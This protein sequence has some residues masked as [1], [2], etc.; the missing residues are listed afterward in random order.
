MIVTAS[1]SNER[2]FEQ[3]LVMLASL[4]KNSVMDDVTVHLIDCTDEHKNRVLKVLPV[5]LI[6]R[7]SC[8]AGVDKKGFMV[9]YRA[10]AVLEAMREW[11]GA[12]AWFDTDVIV[13]K[14][15]HHFWDDVRPTCLKV[16]YR[17]GAP[18]RSLF[19]AGIFAVGV[20]AATEKMVEWWAGKIDG[21]NEWYADQLWLYRAWK[22]SEKKVRLI[23]M[24]AE[25]N[26][27][28]DSK[29]ENPFLDESTIWHCKSSHFEHPD[30]QKEYLAYQEY[31][32]RL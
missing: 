10:G 22:K 1:D 6:E 15:L 20:S 31:L 32:E 3:L 19:Q 12:V 7:A 11:G 26:N 18:E 8:P 29:K 30:Y 5:A 27:V 2:S 25:Y 4:R 28:G 23:R 24:S 13:R 17:R 21:K 16:M 9:C 14:D